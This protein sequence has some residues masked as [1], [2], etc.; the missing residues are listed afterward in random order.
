MKSLLPPQ[1]PNV[2]RFPASQRPIA[3]PADS[4]APRRAL[5]HALVMD[6]HRRGVLAPGVVEA[7]LIGAGVDP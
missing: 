4:T 1:P 2:I 3:A 7:L 5:T 6:Q